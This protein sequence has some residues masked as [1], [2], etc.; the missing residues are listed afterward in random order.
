MALALLIVALL[1]GPFDLISSSVRQNTLKVILCGILGAIVVIPLAIFL[2]ITVI[3]IPLV[4]LEVLLVGCA[5]LVGYIAVALFI[6]NRMATALK[7]PGLHMLWMTA[8]GL[9]I[10]W[11]IGW[12]PFLG[13]TV[14]SVA[15][16]LGFG[17]VL[18]TVF[19]SISRRREA[20]AA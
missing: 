4:V 3:G 1:P 20:R 10:L 2:M 6:G 7:R 8:I 5:M 14:K 9:V 15:V 11:V 19:S 18:V 13:P 17:A 16:V 12:V